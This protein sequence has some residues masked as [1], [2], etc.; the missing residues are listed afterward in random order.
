MGEWRGVKER[1]PVAGA[2]VD[3]VAAVG[4]TRVMPELHHLAVD[5]EVLVQVHFI[6]FKKPKIAGGVGILAAEGEPRISHGL[7]A[8]ALDGCA[9]GGQHFQF[10]IQRRL[11][12]RGVDLQHPLLAGSGGETIQVRVRAVGSIDAAGHLGGQGEGGGL[13]GRVIGLLLLRVRGFRIG[14][15]A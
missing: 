6:P 5:V 9:I 15:G 11:A 7:Q 1:V 8:H 3:N 13:R 12:A 2:G 4:T 10:G 14:N